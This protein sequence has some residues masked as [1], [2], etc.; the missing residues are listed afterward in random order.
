[1][2]TRTLSLG[3]LLFM[4]YVFW[5]TSSILITFNTWWFPNRLLLHRFLSWTSDLCI[6]LETSLRL[7]RRY[8]DPLYKLITSSMSTAPNFFFSWGSS[9]REHSQPS[10]CPRQKLEYPSQTH[11]SLIPKIQST[12]NSVDL[13]SS[14]I[15]LQCSNF[16]LLHCCF[17]SKVIIISCL[18]K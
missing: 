2:L 6:Q 9:L 16:S 18:K 3:A 4:F 7:S 10:Q 11:T 15:S 14:W 13:M 17:P 12:T 5:T 8:L 1:M